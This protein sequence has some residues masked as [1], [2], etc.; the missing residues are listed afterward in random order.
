MSWLAG[1]IPRQHRFADAK[2]KVQLICIALREENLELITHSIFLAHLWIKERDRIDFED[3]DNLSEMDQA[4]I[5]IQLLKESFDRWF[6][7]MCG[8]Q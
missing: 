3:T 4:G 2:K 6:D 1:G 7:N 5:A 8:I